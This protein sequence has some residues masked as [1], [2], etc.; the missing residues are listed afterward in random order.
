MMCL[1][2]FDRTAMSNANM[3]WQK[4]TAVIVSGRFAFS[5][6]T[7]DIFSVHSCIRLLV[8]ENSLMELP[9]ILLPHAVP[10]NA[11]LPPPAVLG[12]VRP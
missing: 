8:V 2:S 4:T 11:K 6:N 9:T 3:K 12:P 7:R 1:G 5:A 10:Y